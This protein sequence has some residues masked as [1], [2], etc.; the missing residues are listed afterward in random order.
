MIHVFCQYRNEADDYAASMG[1][2]EYKFVAEYEWVFGSQKLI[3]HELNTARNRFDY[4]RM[5]FALSERCS[6]YLTEE[7]I[8]E[9]AKDR[10]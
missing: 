2:K 7:E 6:V 9:Q 5:K 1:I 3:V 4:D 8:D 10:G